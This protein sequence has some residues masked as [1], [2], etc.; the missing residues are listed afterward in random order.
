MNTLDS[1]AT[2][3][4]TVRRLNGADQPAI[5]IATKVRSSRPDDTW[6]L[7]LS[8]AQ[9]V[10]KL[11]VNVPSCQRASSIVIDWVVSREDNPNLATAKLVQ[12]VSFDITTQ[13]APAS[14]V[15]KRVDGS[16]RFF[17]ELA[18][19]AQVKAA[20]VKA[21]HK[22]I[23]IYD[24]TEISGFGLDTV[25][26]PF[27]LPTAF[28]ASHQASAALEGRWVPAESPAHLVGEE[29]FEEVNQLIEQSMEAFTE[30]ENSLDDD[31]GEIDEM[32]VHSEWR[33]SIFNAG[34]E[35]L[36]ELR[37]EGFFA[38]SPELVVN[39]WHMDDSPSAEEIAHRCNPP[40]IAESYLTQHPPFY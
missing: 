7:T 24:R 20:L 34:I 5:A 12:P 28:V 39:L 3:S 15:T 10:T 40:K 31:D 4:L 26:D 16:P 13:S 1:Q 38:D 23:S 27:L 36:V 30:W 35:A 6:Q 33:L 19:Q 21:W 22:L 2:G 29:F 37:S 18:L 14:A 32:R 9:G 17:D 25:G 11:A 8:D